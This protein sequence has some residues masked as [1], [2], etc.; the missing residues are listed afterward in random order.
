MAD[1]DM[2]EVNR[3]VVARFRAGGEI[4][5]MHR[6]RLLLLTTTGARSGS[7]HTTPMMVVPDGDRWLVVASNNG[8]P[9]TPDWYANLVAHPDVA[10]EVGDERVPATA[11][12][13]AG[14]D[15]DLAWARVLEV[16]PFFAEH[17]VRAGRRLPV[18]ALTR[19]AT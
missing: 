17:Q 11:R 5:G 16:A 2:A 15:R 18:V 13:L 6:D 9:R 1:P 19:R 10:V 14:E 7:E 8:N 4:P 12:P 3:N